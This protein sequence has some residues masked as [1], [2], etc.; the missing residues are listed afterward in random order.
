MITDGVT[1]PIE[2]L[3]RSIGAQH[4]SSQFYLAGSMALCLHLDHRTAPDLDL[5]SASN[6]LRSPNRRDILGSVLEFDPAC[7]VETARDGFLYLRSRHG[8]GARLYYYPYPM[9]AQTE[10]RFGVEIASL[11]DL[12]LMKL[13]AIISRG[14]K[15]DFVDLYCACR[16]VPLAGLLALAP[17]KFSHVHD[18]G[19]QALKGISDLAQA[20]GEPMPIMKSG[21]DWNDVVAWVE[22]EVRGLA[23]CTV[24]LEAS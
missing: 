8:V 7:R 19:L 22:E 12:A 10:M 1:P 3:L 16:R 20:D 9:A 11:E 18:F 23:R 17:I 4:W 14:T 5:M 21:T 6:R 15:R 13:G 2:E 24:G